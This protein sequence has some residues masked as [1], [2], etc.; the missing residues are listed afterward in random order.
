LAGWHQAVIGAVNQ[1]VSGYDLID[2]QVVAVVNFRLNKL[3][4]LLVNA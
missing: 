1:A 4:R 3:P 2:K